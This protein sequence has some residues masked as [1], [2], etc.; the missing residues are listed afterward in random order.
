MN[1]RL[2]ACAHA[3]MQ[4]LTHQLAF[5]IKRQKDLFYFTHPQGVNNSLEPRKR[6]RQLREMAWWEMGGVTV[7][8]SPE[9]ISVS[10]CS[11][12]MMTNYDFI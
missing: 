6:Q 2:H 8:C 1:V 5:A 12:V 11:E 10:L 3:R 7:G 4:I 9:D